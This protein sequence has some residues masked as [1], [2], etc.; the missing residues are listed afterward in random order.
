MRNKF[1][2]PHAGDSDRRAFLQA[3]VAVVTSAAIG[4]S[5]GSLAHAAAASS[6]KSPRSG[7]RRRAQSLPPPIDRLACPARHAAAET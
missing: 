6:S 3:S 2:K 7:A 4:G 5:Y 1:G